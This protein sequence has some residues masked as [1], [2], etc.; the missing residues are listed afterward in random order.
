MKRTGKIALGLSL[1]LVLVIIV[2]W[3]SDRKLKDLGHPGLR[4]FAHQVVVNYPKGFAVDPVEL[5]IRVNEKELDHLQTVVDDARAR[6]V[7]I[8]EGNEYVGAEVIG[9][10]GSFKA[11][12]RIKGKLTDHV[13]GEKWSF[14][15]VAK[16]DGG[17]QGMQRFSLQH[18]GTRNY[19]Y[20][21]F[22]HRIMEGE[23]VIA[24]RYGFIRLLFNGDDLGIY[25]YEE[26]FGPELLENNERL[27]GP[28]FRFDP[29]LYWEHR[30][31]EMQ[32][33]KLNEPY[34]E[35][36]A[37]S[38]D[39]FRTNAM[40]KDPEAR[41]H[42]E[43]AV[44]LMDAFRRGKLTAS[45]VFDADKLAR[46]HAILDLI[47]GHHSMDFSDVKFYY[48][49]V[50]QRIEPVSYESFSA[51]PIRTLAGSNKYVGKTLETQDL[52]EAYFND[53]VLF[54]AYVHHLERISRTSYLDSVFNALG[55]ALDTASA[56]IYQEFPWKELDRRIFENNQKVIRRL[57]DVPKGFHAHVQDRQGDTLEILAV[58]IE[59]LPLEV[60]GLRVEGGELIAPLEP[61]I[62]PCRLA[63]RMGE[64]MLLRFLVPAPATNEPAPVMSINYSVLG[65]SV[66][67]DLEVF[68]FALNE[69]IAEA[70][71]GA[72]SAMDMRKVPFLQVDEERRMIYIKPGSWTLEKD[73]MIPAGYE[74]R[75]DAPLEIDLQKGA[76]IISRSPLILKGV[77]ERPIRITSTDQSGGGIL[78]IDAGSGSRW[79][80]VEVEGLGPVADQRTMIVFQNA[81]VR[82][83]NC[84]L[85]GEATRDLLQLVRTNA[86]L[87]DCTLAGGRDQVSTTYCQVKM[88]GVMAY[89]AKDDGLVFHGGMADLRNVR[90][91][92]VQGTA[93]KVRAYAEVKI[94]DMSSTEVGRGIDLAEGAKLTLEVATVQTPGIGLVVDKASTRYGPVK[95]DINGLQ[96]EAGESTMKI[97]DG[98][99]VRIQ[100]ELVKE[101][102]LAG[103]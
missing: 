30:L 17:F 3:F 94:T 103:R 61:V 32:K 80:H 14:R 27:K 89:S 33:L 41:G 102:N 97:G 72:M 74:L 67:H 92:N 69:Q 39:A 55:P 91:E 101:N 25:A 59:A 70:S 4:R 22:F 82:M 23:G 63:G 5:E 64:P 93:V 58:P 79:D 68:P 45:Q 7:I 73:L 28:I 100:G 99:E 50:A 40:N 24:L 18:P 62:I 2:A 20:D 12:I 34:A 78:V 85:G 87:I 43:E 53:P 13:K 8:P 38:V 46:R 37:A 90:L 71:L 60:H 10:D 42:F 6:G 19:L 11:K 81:P 36:Q 88:Q 49:P 21:W 29:G 26:H 15:V 83:R 52:H 1:L 16:K 96:I 35:Y 9:P 48:D 76:R 65:A 77:P 57:L 98:N 75:G 95:A 56:I 31:N 86:Q 84:R 51:F 66:Q 44:G 54:R 47:G